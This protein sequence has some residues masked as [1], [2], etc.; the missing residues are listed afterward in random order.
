MPNNLPKYFAN[1]PNAVIVAPAGCGKTELIADSVWHCDGRQL[2]L[3]HTHAGVNSLRKR[4]KKKGVSSKK[5]R[6]ETIHSFAVR[7]ASAYPKA[8][9]IITNEPKTNEEYENVIT[10]A[11]SLLEK[12]LAKKILTESY[13]GVF[14]DEY[15]DCDV[16]QHQ[17]ILK[18]AETLPCRIVGDY[19]QGI[20]DFGGSELVDW[21]IDVYPEFNVLDQLK[22]PWRWKG[23]GGNRALGDWL[24]NTARPALENL[25]SLSIH[26]LESIGVH[27]HPKKNY[28]NYTTELNGHANDFDDIF[29]ICA[30]GNIHKPHTIVEKLNK[31]FRSIE[32]LTG[33]DLF[34]AAEQIHAK[35][36][37]E[38]LDVT[39]EF[40]FKCLTEIT[41]D[42]RSVRSNSSVKFR[43][44]NKIQLKN[45]F[46]R[47]INGE[48]V[49]ISELF[50]FFETYKPTY[51]RWQLWLEMKKGLKLSMTEKVPL[52]EACW[53]VKNKA[54]Y[55]ENRIPRRCVSRTVLLK[56]LEC[57][58]VAVIDADELKRKDF[59]VAITRP[60]KELHIYSETPFYPSIPQEQMP[61]CPECG[62]KLR[63]RNGQ[64][65]LFMGCRNYQEC[66][67]KKSFMGN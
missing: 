60:S 1:S 10:S 36:G 13:D 29:A 49:A 37:E 11:T 58:C 8:S 54:K 66:K 34:D 12:D 48:F 45:F 57:E 22:E 51:K 64:Y 39:L 20:F 38:L 35:S 14:V 43:N 59:Y 23:E 44:E 24:I 17:L 52:V 61:D 7:Y 67:Y 4:L 40:A 46:T 21:D 32:P 2:I 26:G 63:F 33:K 25:E 53:Q 65:G 27:W 50:E 30:S 62:D 41:S 3:T 16:S 31:R 47:I 18:L 56:G 42:S 15:Q 5:Y 28:N 19:L 9:G 55:Y 6:L